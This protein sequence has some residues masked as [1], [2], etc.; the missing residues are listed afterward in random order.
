MS[1]PKE[2]TNRTKFES[3][4]LYILNELKFKFKIYNEISEC[5]DVIEEL[6]YC[7]RV[8]KTKQVPQLDYARDYHHF[9]LVTAKWL[10]EQIC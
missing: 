8:Y 1:W 2:I 10:V 7:D 5:I 9:D 4:P 3:I 6:D